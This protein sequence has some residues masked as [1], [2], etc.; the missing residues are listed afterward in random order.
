[1]MA[2]KTVQQQENIAGGRLARLAVGQKK[3]ETK[4][5]AAVHYELKAGSAGKDALEKG[6]K[7]VQALEERGKRQLAKVRA[8]QQ[9]VLEGPKEAKASLKG[10][11]SAGWQKSLPKVDQLSKSMQAKRNTETRDVDRR[12][13]VGCR[14]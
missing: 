2:L 13:R 12:E 6:K 14:H 10:Q 8:G 9:R 3:S 7:I 11:G 5:K 1:M 4:M